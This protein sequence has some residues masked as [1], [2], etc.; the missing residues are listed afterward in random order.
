MPD[1][2]KT[3]YVPRQLIPWKDYADGQWRRSVRGVDFLGIPSTYARACRAWGKRNGYTATAYVK[4][5]QVEFRLVRLGTAAPEPPEPAAV[6]EAA[7]RR[8]RGPGDGGG[9]HPG[10]GSA[11][12]AEWARMTAVF[13]GPEDPPPPELRLRPHDPPPD[14]A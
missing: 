11:A 14:A 5:N 2:I 9:S 6:P 1:V 8:G 4:G 3:P 10:T 13:M 7:V 12:R